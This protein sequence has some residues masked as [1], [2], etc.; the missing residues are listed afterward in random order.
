MQEDLSDRTKIGMLIIVS[1]IVLALA[2]LIYVYQLSSLSVSADTPYR[3][4][5]ILCISGKMK[6]DGQYE[7]SKCIYDASKQKVD[8]KL[9]IALEANEDYTI[10]YTMGDFLYEDDEYLAPYQTCS[11]DQETGNYAWIFEPT[12][13]NKS[14][15]NIIGI[16]ID[17]PIFDGAL[18]ANTSVL[19]G[20]KKLSEVDYYDATNSKAGDLSTFKYQNKYDMTA[21]GVESNKKEG[22]D[23]TFNQSASCSEVAD[24]GAKYYYGGAHEPG[25]YVSMS[26]TPLVTQAQGTLVS[27]SAN[28]FGLTPNLNGN[29]IKANYK[30]VAN[31]DSYNYEN[32]T[33]IQDTDSDNDG[34]GDSDDTDVDGDGILNQDEKSVQ[35][36]S[37]E[38][39][40]TVISSG[41]S[42]WFNLLISLMVI[43]IVGYFM[44]R[45]K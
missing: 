19:S 29:F 22:Y 8:S 7:S 23:F 10:T 21:S 42:L 35:A 15:S 31:L 3:A 18:F 2:V 6:I 30:I 33:I 5:G 14:L 11:L 25:D 45:K 37:S 16:A 26:F 43:V 4:P 13:F 17:E 9:D 28:S 32:T 27:Y 41:A 40:W 36:A 20:H 44:F 12:D 34:I 24:S 38:D 1:V 39:V